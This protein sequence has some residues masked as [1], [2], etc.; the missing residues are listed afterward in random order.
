MFED[1]NNKPYY[2][3]H[4][5]G[6]FDIDT[7]QQQGA[8]TL[9]EQKEKADAANETLSNKIF[10]YVKNGFLIAASAYILKGIIDSQQKK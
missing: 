6:Q 2:V 10:R 9:E 7:I 8:L 1:E 4:A 5:V 3:K